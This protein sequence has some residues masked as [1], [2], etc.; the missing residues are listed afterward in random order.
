MPP[1]RTPTPSSSTSASPAPLV[2]RADLRRREV[3]QTLLPS[4]KTALGQ[5]MT[6]AP[7]AQ[8]MASLFVPPASSEVRI[9]DPG[10]GVGSLTAALVQSLCDLPN[11]A[12]EVTVTCYE[13]DRTLIPHL[14][15]T[16]QECLRTAQSAGLIFHSQLRELDFI[17]DAAETLSPDLFS[18]SAT[19]QSYTHAILNPPYKKIQTG[20]LHRKLL[21]RTGIETSNLYSAF[22]ALAIKL[23]APS[24]QLVAITPRSFCNGPYFL[25]FR[26]LLL[27]EMSILR[28][29]T[30]ESREEAF[31]DDNVL[32]ENVILFAAKSPQSDNVMLSSSRGPQFHSITSRI[33]PF[34]EVIRDGDPYLIIHIPTTEDDK[35]VALQLRSLRFTLDDLSIQ[36]STGPVV[37]FRLR[38]HIHHHATSSS[39]PLLYPAHFKSGLV[40]WPQ[41]DGRKPNAIDLNDQTRKWLMPQGNYAVTRRFSS[42]EERRRVVGAVFDPART[43]GKMIGFENHLN[44]FHTGGHGLPAAIARGLCIFLNSTLVDR[45]FRQFNGH[46]QV[47]ASDLRNLRYPSLDIL[48]SLGS[49]W[50]EGPLPSQETIDALVDTALAREHSR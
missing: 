26:K 4:T 47:N 40:Q 24:G 1:I 6:P 32:Q 19:A 44:V 21:S 36:V 46:T 38:P 25:P 37:D 30:F 3:A 13:I 41:P 29:H 22:V 43:P 8:F 2:A 33:A 16:L 14:Q 11:A 45:F 48:H 34:T 12:K 49:A 35:R 23:L 9:L 10:A 39:V 31:R 7:I 27:A 5:F 42:K 15:G 18:P 28:I 50:R 17:Q 20:S